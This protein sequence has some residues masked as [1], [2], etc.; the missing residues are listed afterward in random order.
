LSHDGRSH[1]S[2][3]AAAAG[4]HARLIQIGSL[5]TLWLKSGRQQVGPP[6]ISFTQAWLEQLGRAQFMVWSFD[7]DAVAA[8][9]SLPLAPF[10]FPWTDVTQDYGLTHASHMVSGGVAGRSRKD[11]K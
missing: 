2:R 11:G 8:C 4:S 9:A 1:I 5:Y 10:F 6:K 7:A 3:L